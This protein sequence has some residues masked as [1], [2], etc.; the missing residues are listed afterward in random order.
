MDG[1]YIIIL[2]Q[3]KFLINQGLGLKFKV[4]YWWPYGQEMPKTGKFHL[5]LWS[6]IWLNT[7]PS[8]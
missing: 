8:S 5:L 3:R 6:K 2:N 1:Y 4:L 7:A